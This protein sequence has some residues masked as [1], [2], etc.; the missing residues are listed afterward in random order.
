MDAAAEVARRPDAVHLYGVDVL[1]TQDCLA[2]F[3]DYGPTFVKWLDDSS[4]NVLFEDAGTAQRAI[5]GC[6][7]P[8]PP[9]D[10]APDCAGAP[11]HTPTSFAACNRAMQKGCLLQ[12]V[13]RF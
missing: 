3:S 5:A 9:D 10:T 8:L 6:G 12:L 2:Y 7:R 4:C 1:S 13:L 11:F